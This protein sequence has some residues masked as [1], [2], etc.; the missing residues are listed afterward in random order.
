MP[1]TAMFGDLMGFPGDPRFKEARITV[2]KSAGVCHQIAEDVLPVMRDQNVSSQ[3]LMHVRD[4]PPCLVP[5][6]HHR[7]LAVRT[8]TGSPLF[9]DRMKRNHIQCI[10]VLACG[11]G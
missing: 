8:D 11:G 9:A 6:E 1:I 10:V 3:I 7:A 4:L 2:L 5:S